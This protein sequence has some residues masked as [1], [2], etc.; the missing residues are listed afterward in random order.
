[1]NKMNKVRVLIVF[2]VGIVGI[3]VV[4]RLIGIWG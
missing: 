4:E 2:G 1:M 3:L